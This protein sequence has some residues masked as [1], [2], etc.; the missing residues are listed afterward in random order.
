MHALNL[1]VKNGIG[2]NIGFT[3]PFDIFNKPQLI[4]L[5]YQLKFITEIPLLNMGFQLRYLGHI[6]YPRIIS[7]G[8]GNKSE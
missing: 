3:L 5:L 4:A 6:I 1:H 2:I 8:F 7:Q